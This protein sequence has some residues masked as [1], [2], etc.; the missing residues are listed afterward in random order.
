MSKSAVENVLQPRP[1]HRKEPMAAACGR[2]FSP[3][4]TLSFWCRETLLEPIKR[5]DKDWQSQQNAL[6]TDQSI[7]HADSDLTSF[8]FQTSFESCAASWEVVSCSIPS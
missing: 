6:Q 8:D 2:A 5:L 7:P 4:C 1:L 3:S